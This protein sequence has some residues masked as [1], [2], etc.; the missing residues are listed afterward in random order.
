MKKVSLIALLGTICIFADANAVNFRQYVSLKLTAPV[1]SKIE[2]K[3]K[4]NVTDWSA[5]MQYQDDITENL[6][7]ETIDGLVFAYGVQLFDARVELEY[8]HYFN[9][10]II[11]D[12]DLSIQNYALFA[13]AYYDIKTN[14]PFAPY[15]GLGF[16]YNRQK[17]REDSETEILHSL[18][19]KL[20]AGVGWKVSNMVTLDIGYR[21]VN[22][23]TAE[24]TEN[25]MMSPSMEYSYKV[26][27]NNVAHELMLGARIS[28]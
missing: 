14:S 4:I 26:E 8:N 15:F 28:F 3:E 2:L 19:W 21:Y 23:G 1:S 17:F 22:F 13:N 24:Y 5:M 11:K 20:A 27:I 9:D 10:A 16:G 7:M 6:D 12:T 25:G 18:A